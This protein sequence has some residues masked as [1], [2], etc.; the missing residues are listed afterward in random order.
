MWWYVT[1]RNS[2]VPK[3][4]LENAKTHPKRVALK[5]EDRQWSFSQLN[6]FS[7]R[8]ANVMIEY[9]FQPGEEVALMMNNRMEYVGIWLGLAKA[10]LVT[11]FINTSQRSKGLVHSISTV[12]CKAVIFDDENEPGR[13]PIARFFRTT[14]QQIFP[15]STNSNQTVLSPIKTPALLEIRNELDTVTS[16]QY[17]YFGDREPKGNAKSLS[18]FMKDSSPREPH[19]LAN[20]SYR[21]KQPSVKQ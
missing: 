12:H 14:F 5:F 8:V 11:A 17:F 13:L 21:G 16:L 1:R 15:K 19:T 20:T 10:G 3:I 18:T 6:E 2:S 7:N 9:G 4:F